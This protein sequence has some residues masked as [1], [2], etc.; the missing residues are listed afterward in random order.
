MGNN[1]SQE[2]KFCPKLRSKG[3]TEV[4]F[5]GTELGYGGK[6][7]KAEGEQNAQNK[8]GAAP[9]AARALRACWVYLKGMERDGLGNV[10]GALCARLRQLDIKGLG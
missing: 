6:T 5:Q 7:K 9:V 3:R 2:C 8:S 1:E 4:R 10:M